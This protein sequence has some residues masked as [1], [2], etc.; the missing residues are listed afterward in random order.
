MLLLQKCHTELV[1]RLH[2][3]GVCNIFLLIAGGSTTTNEETSRPSTPHSAGPRSSPLPTP[4]QSRDR[5]IGVPGSDPHRHSPASSLG[6][7]VTPPRPSLGSHHLSSL[8]GSSFLHQHDSYLQ[9]AGQKN[10][11]SYM[12][13][14]HD[15]EMVVD[16]DEE[17][18][19]DEDDSKDDKKDGSLLSNNKRK[20]KTRTVFSRSQVFQL[21]ST[22]DMKRYLSSS[23]RAGLAA[24]LHLTET[25]VK[26]WFQNRRNK[27]KRQLAAELEA[28]NMAQAAQ[29]LVRVPILY[30]EAA[31]TPGLQHHLGAPVTSASSYP[32]LYYHHHHHHAAAS[33]TQS[34]SPVP[35]RPPLPS[36]V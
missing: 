19:G 32:S 34:S 14:R 25:Q 28:A 11:P 12:D 3:M 27:W 24:S 16:G 13:R 22:F 2:L 5:G 23:E 35:P 31:S 17:V 8:L 29:R 4:S 36:L 21:E 6:D 18:D 26:I 30:H 33:S 10:L 20:K 9:L 1:L 15:E 7:E